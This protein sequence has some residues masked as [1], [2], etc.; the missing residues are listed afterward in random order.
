MWCLKAANVTRILLWENEGIPHFRLSVAPGAAVRIHARISRSFF[1][2][3]VGAAPKTSTPEGQAQPEPP[4]VRPTAA[5]VTTDLTP[6][7]R[8]QRLKDRK[9]SQ[10]RETTFSTGASPLDSPF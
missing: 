1:R 9:P 4:T 10:G 7:E 6:D 2:A 5:T 8:R 3:P